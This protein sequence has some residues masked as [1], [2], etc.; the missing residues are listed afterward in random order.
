[1]TTFRCRRCGKEIPLALRRP[2]REFVASPLG[3]KAGRRLVEV[4]YC[5]ACD[6]DAT[7]NRLA[8]MFVASLGIGLL[9]CAVEWLAALF[10]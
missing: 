5:P 10:R 7:G 2:A 9:V 6:R 8:E 1:M 3:P 4:G